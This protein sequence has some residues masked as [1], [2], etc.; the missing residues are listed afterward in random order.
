[1]FAAPLLGAVSLAMLS[2]GA[3]AVARSVQ[4]G[5]TVY[6]ASLTGAVAAFAAGA[7]V[8]QAPW[9][10]GLLY[11]NRGSDFSYV[12]DT[13]NEAATALGT[14][15]PIVGS[16][17]LLGIVVV[18]ARWSSKRGDAALS[19]RAVGVALLVVVLMI[20]NLAAQAHVEKAKTVDSGLAVAVLAAIAGLT[21]VISAMR[22]CRA[23]ANAASDVPAIP[24]ATALPPRT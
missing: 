24:T 13:V 6:A 15:L 18:V 8:A 10:Y 2:Y 14:V 19:T 16:A 1:V 9:I 7:T 11:T 23:A 5:V 17:A 21:A 12:A 20:V 3:F 22:L 4:H